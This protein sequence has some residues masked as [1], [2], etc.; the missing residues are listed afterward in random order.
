MEKNEKVEELPAMINSS[1]EDEGVHNNNTTNKLKKNPT[2]AFFH[3]GWLFKI[4][5]T[6][7]EEL[8]TLMDKSAYE[9]YLKSQEEDH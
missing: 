1:A 9:A 2:F 6:K 4:K 3:S 7:P 8:D 5:L